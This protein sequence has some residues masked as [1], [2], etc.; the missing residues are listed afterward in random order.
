MRDIFERVADLSSF[1]ED[2]QF[3]SAFCGGCPQAPKLY[4][5]E[6]IASGDPAQRECP[7]Q[8]YFLDIEEHLNRAEKEIIATMKSAECIPI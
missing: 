1:L 7:R 3:L 8:R 6:C 4:F 2:P 5:Q